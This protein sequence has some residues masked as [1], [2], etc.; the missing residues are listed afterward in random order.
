MIAFVSIY[1]Y[2]FRII[3]KGEKIYYTE[4]VEKLQTLEKVTGKQGDIQVNN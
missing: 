3:S 1:L 2:L 4:R